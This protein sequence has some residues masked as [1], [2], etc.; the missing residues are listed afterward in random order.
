M[1][2]VVEALLDFFLGAGS[3]VKSAPTNTAAR[4]LGGDTTHATYKLPRGAM[5]GRRAQLSSPVLRAFRR[6]W[7]SVQ[8]HDVDEISVF[9]PRSLLH[10]DLR[11]R[12]AKQRENDT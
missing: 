12:Q 4:L 1:L 7:S 3:L 2:R 5:V 11:C 9:P 10:V 6:R 8:A